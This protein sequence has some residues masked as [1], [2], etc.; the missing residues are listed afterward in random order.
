MKSRKMLFVAQFIG[1]NNKLTGTVIEI[2]GDKCTVE[3]EGRTVKALK[4]NVNEVGD[5]TSFVASSG[6]SDGQS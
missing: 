2:D 3:V 6:K 1:E 5:K 4:V